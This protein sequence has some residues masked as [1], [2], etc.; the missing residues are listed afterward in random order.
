MIGYRMPFRLP[1]LI[2][3]APRLTGNG[4]RRV[5]GL[6]GQVY[7][8]RLSS[9]YP[10]PSRSGRAGHP[11][12]PRKAEAL[13]MIRRGDVFRLAN[14][15]LD[16]APDP[17]VRY[18][19]LQGVLHRSPSDRGL[20]AARQ[21]AWR[22][23]HLEPIRSEQRSNGGWGH[24]HGARNPPAY[25]V[26]NGEHGIDRALALGLDASHPILRKAVRYLEGLLT[27]RL[28]FPEGERNERCVLGWRLFAASKLAEVDATRRSLHTTWTTWA[29]I[30]C[31]SFARGRYDPMAERIAHRQLHGIRGELR[32]LHLSNRYAVALLGS[33]AGDLPAR[34]ERA[35]VSWLCTRPGGI[36]YLG[37]PV[38]QAPVRQNAY[39]VDRWF[40][41]HEVLSR[42][43]SWRRLSI[44]SMQWLWSQQRHSGFWDL[45]R[46]AAESAYFPLSP[47][48]RSPVSRRQD[49]SVRVLV[50]ISTLSGQQSA[51]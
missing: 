9:S 28:P 4:L 1:K 19:L 38:G 26:P 20:I 39:V 18:Q 45:G 32:Y 13:D 42:F 33:R 43:P 27:A 23:P 22:T 51:S 24:F 48:W 35:Y 34:V 2:H 37:V 50:L 46:R 21:H 12:F 40:T 10:Y 15:L 41:S 14:Q 8:L 5:L 11:P 3:E 44:A 30:V 6:A 47:D 7:L 49:W 16:E 36:I 29:H 25:R 31:T 17:V